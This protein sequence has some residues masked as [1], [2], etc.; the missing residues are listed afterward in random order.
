MK[1]AVVFGVLAVV[2]ALVLIMNRTT[3]AGTTITVASGDVAVTERNEPREIR[4]FWF[5]S[6]L[7]GA[8]IVVLLI[9]VLGTKRSP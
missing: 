5:G 9:A 2:A 6:L 1:S 3:L 8:G 7:G 4:L